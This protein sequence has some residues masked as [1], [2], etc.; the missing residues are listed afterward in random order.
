M[1]NQEN[2]LKVKQE[3]KNALFSGNLTLSIQTT[4]KFLEKIKVEMEKTS[5]LDE[6]MIYIDLINKLVQSKEKLLKLKYKQE[7]KR[8]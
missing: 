4:D 8:Q 7:E 6:K 2:V 5:S 3:N 1:S